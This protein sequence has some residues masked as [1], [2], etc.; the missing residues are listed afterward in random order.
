MEATKMRAALR[1][2]NIDPLFFIFDG[3]FM[4]DFRAHENKGH[5]GLSFTKRAS[6]RY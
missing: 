1:G 2:Q 4:G 6:A 5:F 3:P